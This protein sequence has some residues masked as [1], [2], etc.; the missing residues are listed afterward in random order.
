MVEH[1]YRSGLELYV[2]SSTAIYVWELQDPTWQDYACRLL[3]IDQSV[4]SYETLDVVE[5][6]GVEALFVRY[7]DQQG[8]PGITLFTGLDQYTLTINL[9]NNPGCTE[10][11]DGIDG[12][13]VFFHVVDSFKFIK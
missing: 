13:T 2:G 7:H 10:A 11:L 9:V 1:L 8:N 6:D 12:S 4:L 3:M 5:L